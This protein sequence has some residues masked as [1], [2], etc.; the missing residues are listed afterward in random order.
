MKTKK[1]VFASI[2]IALVFIATSIIKIPISVGFGYVHLGDSVVMLA[3]MLLGPIYGAV[4][5]AFGSAL[6]DY[7]GGYAMYMIPTFIVKGLLALLVGLAYKDLKGNLKDTSPAKTIYHVIVAVII[8]V[9]GYFLSDLLLANFVIADLEGSTPLAYA[10][11]GLPWNALQAVFG[12]V[13][14]ILL[15]VPL[16]KPFEN[17]YN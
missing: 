12:A 8:V 11:F 2:F 10:A 16:K 4:S 5:S 17:I 3:G 9:G 14:S 15:Y 1:L 6:A 7:A 13:V